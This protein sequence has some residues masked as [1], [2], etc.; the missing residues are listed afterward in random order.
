MINRFFRKYLSIIF[1]IATLVGVFHHHNDL[2]QHHDCQLCTIQSSIANADMPVDVVYL[3]QLDIVS[4][5]IVVEFANFHSQKTK[6][7][8]NARAPPSI[9]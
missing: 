9:S 3:S 2:K 5:A 1:V 7:T 8:L 6:N 4:E